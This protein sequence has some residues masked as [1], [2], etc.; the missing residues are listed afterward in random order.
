MNF[1]QENDMSQSTHPSKSYVS[2]SLYIFPTKVAT[3]SPATDL[4]RDDIL[5]SSLNGKMHLKILGKTLQLCFS[6]SIKVRWFQLK[7]TF[8]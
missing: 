3:K 1:L 7:Y 4:H 8:N 2:E 6:Y 5:Q